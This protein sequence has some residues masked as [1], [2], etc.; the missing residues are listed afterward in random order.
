MKFNQIN[1]R[2]NKWEN[3]I[4]WRRCFKAARAFGQVN[5]FSNASKDRQFLVAIIIILVVKSLRDTRQGS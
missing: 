4:Y 1:T 2:M 3:K 5:A